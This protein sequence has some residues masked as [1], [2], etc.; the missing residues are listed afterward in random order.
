MASRLGKAALNRRLLNITCDL[1]KRHF[2][3]LEVSS[4]RDPQN[5]T[6]KK[7]GK[8]QMLN[9]KTYQYVII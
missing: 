6:K 9:F 8:N 3:Q 7:L 2:L 4:G 5:K 1:N